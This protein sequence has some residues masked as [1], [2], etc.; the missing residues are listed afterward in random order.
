VSSGTRPSGQLT[1]LFYD[2]T[3]TGIKRGQKIGAIGG[4][5]DHVHV[6]TGPKQLAAIKKLATDM[7]LAI[8]SEAEGHPGDGVH[9]PTSY[10]YKHRAVDV[11]GPPERM[12]AFTKRVAKKYRV[13]L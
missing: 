12:A 7:G 10:H 4:H 9:T 13:K 3:G 1:E 2:P 8:T 5:A 6:A 11:A